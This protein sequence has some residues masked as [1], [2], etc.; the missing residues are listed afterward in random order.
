M[1]DR[2]TRFDAAVIRLEASMS[3]LESSTKTNSKEKVKSAVE[4]LH[5]EYQSIDALLQ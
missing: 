3:E 4:K 5:T 1:S 2:Q